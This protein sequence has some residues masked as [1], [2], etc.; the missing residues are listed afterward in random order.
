MRRRVIDRDQELLE[1]IHRSEVCYV[2]MV[3][4]GGVPY[5]VPMNFG[6]EENILYLHGAK[7]GRKIDV[8]KS[9]PLVCVAFS[10]DH[11]LRYQHEQVACSWSMKYRS[12]L[13]HG[14]V[15]MIDD[16]DEKR[17]ALNVVMRKYAGRN[18]EFSLP[19]LREVQP[20]RVIVAELEGRAYGL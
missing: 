19:A 18:F 7:T 16:P 3:A 1:V 5:V 12:V 10:T 11:E 4:A 13:L 17:H 6:F 15:E 9:N 14:R 20:F 2:S 8:L